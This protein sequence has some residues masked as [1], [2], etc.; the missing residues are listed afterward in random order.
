M[1][2]IIAVSC[3]TGGGGTEW[4]ARVSGRVVDSTGT[5]CASAKVL[6]LPVNYNPIKDTITDTSRFAVTDNTGSYSI[7]VNEPGSFNIEVTSSGNR[8]KALITGVSVTDVEKALVPDAVV[9]E[10][11]TIIINISDNSLSDNPYVYISGTTSYVKISEGK[12]TLTGVPSGS[13]P[14]LYYLKNRNDMQL[15]R[16][17]IEVPSAGIVFV[18]E[19]S[20]WNY[21]KKILLNTTVSGAGIENDLYNFPLLLRLTKDN[22]DF[23][24]SKSSG[25]DIY[26]TKTDGTRIP[27]EIEHWDQLAMRAEIWVKID[28]VFG[29]NFNQSLIM[30]W[31]NSDIISNSSPSKVFDT[32]D[33]FA[34]VWHLG[35][36]NN[37]TI[38]EATGNGIHGNAVSTTPVNGI[39]GLAQSF[40]GS[41]SHIQ[42]QETADSKLNVSE[43]DTFSVSA[44]VKTNILDSNYQGIIYK[45]N[46]QYGLQ[47][48]P[49]KNWEFFTFSDKNGWEATNFPANAN[50]WHL[51]TGV[52]IGSRQYLYLDAVCVDSSISVVS[53]KLSRDTLTHLE[54]G[55]CQNGGLEPDR[56][57]NGIIDEVRILHSITSPDWI[58]LCFMNQKE[59]NVVVIW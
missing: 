55:H 30:F 57:F 6:L 15:L 41:K 36:F 34:G 20:N 22:F 4:E 58:K 32:S 42:I 53:S 21:S 28:T 17:G 50:S 40:D 23:S 11:G 12:A 8:N 51:L 1:S 2:G 27:F 47:I 19:S 3:S 18:K 39:I 46:L 25:D 13:I 26:F 38:P 37:A 44:W 43:N 33:G 31:G 10:C 52:R 45:S 7:I 49:E 24:R 54:I 29:N 16:S 56:F 5:P 48:R 9:R 35:Q 14:P 59:E